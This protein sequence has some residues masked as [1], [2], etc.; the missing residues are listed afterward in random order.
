MSWIETLTDLKEA[1]RPCA[2]V[3]VVDHKGSVPRE[4][5]ARMIVAGGKLAWGTIGGG[6]LEKLAIEHADEL[7]RT[8]R[9]ASESVSYPLSSAAGQC[10]GGNVTLFYETFPWTRR[11]LVIFGAG[12]VAQA[13]A[14][15]APWLAADVQLID[16]RAEEDLQPVPPKV[17]EWELLCIDA[18]EG[19]VDVIDPE[20]LV[21]VMTHSHALDLEVVAACL[22]RGG[23]PY[24]GLI[25]SERKWQRFR[26]QLA[27]RGFPSEAIDAVR[28]PIGVTKTSKD[29]SAI[30]LSAA[31]ELVDVWARLEARAPD[32]V[33]SPG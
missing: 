21:L 8:G 20:T 33:D 29:P 17:R 12:H 15:L 27:Q 31:A 11:R 3:V 1:R 26:T 25:G 2:M 10:C 18:P 7:L 24:V 19:E 28:C 16:P 30:A 13:V 4:A 6:N 14:G 22:R 32:A 5:G 9:P 23:F